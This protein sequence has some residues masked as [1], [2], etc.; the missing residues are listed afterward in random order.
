PDLDVTVKETGTAQVQQGID[1]LGE[2]L[3]GVPPTTT[4]GFATAGVPD[5][6]SHIQQVNAAIDGTPSSFTVT[7]NVNISGAIA[8]IAQLDRMMPHSPAKEGPLSTLPNW[9][10]LFAGIAASA[11]KYGKDAVD[12]VKSYVDA[13]KAIY[14][15]LGAEL[16]FG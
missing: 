13:I 12:S 15:S 8:S 2:S 9:D 4:V 14:D 16:T 11:D 3:H 7:A 10:A 1:H 6:L 5:T